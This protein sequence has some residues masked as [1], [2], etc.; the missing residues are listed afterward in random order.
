[1][2]R[3]EDPGTGQLPLL[4]VNGGLLFDHTLLWPALAPLAA[5]RQLIF[6]DQ[7]GRG[8][9]SVP[10]AARS[11]RIEFDASDLATLP[12]ALGHDRLHMLG[13]SWGGG[14]A[15]RSIGFNGDAIHSLTL[16][17]AVGLTS[18]DWLPGLTDAAA[19]RLAGTELERL[20]AADAAVR[21]GATGAADPVALSEYA[22]AIYPAWFHDQTLATLFAPPRSTSVTG[23]AVSARLRREGYDW[24]GTIG[25]LPMPTLLVHGESDL[26]PIR[27]AEHTTRHLGSRATLLPVPSAGHNP[28]WEQPSIVFPA[29]ERFLLDAER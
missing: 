17:D 27:V 12:S 16:I 15:L 9:S 4:C 26:I 14:I 13:H 22:A 23:A 3:T 24:T 18:A 5:T 28:F 7:R 1:M 10:P 6:Y 25:A 20:F 19:A 2:F 11:S 29:I 21:P 8:R